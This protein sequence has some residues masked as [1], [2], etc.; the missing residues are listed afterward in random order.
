MPPATGYN[1][2][3]Q[4]MLASGD[5][6]DVVLFP[7]TNDQSF[8]NA[9]KDGIIKP[10]NDYLKNAANLQK[11][12]YKASWDQLRVK[13]DDKI[14]GIPRTSVVR[15]DAFFVRKDWLKNIGFTLPDNGEVTL[16]QFEEILNKF[17]NNDPDQNGKKDTYGYGGAY[18]PQKVLEVIVPGSFGLTGWQASKGGEYEYMNPMY[19]RNG[20]KFKK[21]LDFTSRMYKSGFFDPDSATNDGTKQRERFV[22]GLTGVFPGFA[23]HY[24][25]VNAD[26]KKNNPAAELSYMFVQNEQGKVEGGALTTSSTGLWGFWAITS[27]AKNPQKV[28]DVLDAWISDDMWEKTGEGYEGLD[29]VLKDG[30]KAAIQP[31]APA[32]QFRRSTMRRAND[33]SFFLSVGMSKEQTNMVVPWLDKAIATVVPAK[34]NAF[35]PEA[36]K[37]PNYLDYTKVWQQT[38]MKIVMGAEPVS[39]FDELLAGWYKNGGEDYVKQ[40][41]D[42]IKKMES[43]K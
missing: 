35:V 37:K 31:P 22:R 14:Y 10:V 15:N 5:Y 18:N 41:N 42:Y 36:A 29:Y 12:T 3:L 32:A 39:K 30:L 26:L 4:L 40:M 27:T 20:D 13:Q 38:V 34:D 1:E 16:A 23:G 8:Q 9:V 21:A 25:G 17:T 2:R 11:H 33:V 43:S 24:I 19:D 6:P 28:V 7:E